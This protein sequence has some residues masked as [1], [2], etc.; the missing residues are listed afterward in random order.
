[1]LN[2]RNFLLYWYYLYKLPATLM[3]YC[4]LLVAELAPEL[5][6]SNSK[7]VVRGILIFKGLIIIILLIM[8]GFPGTNPATW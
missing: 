5:V 3:I 1:M 7:N 4:K 8:P 2:D 6:G